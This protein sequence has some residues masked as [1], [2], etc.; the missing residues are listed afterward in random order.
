MK[1]NSTTNIKKDNILKDMSPSL[2]CIKDVSVLYDKNKKQYSVKL[3]KEIVE[4]L[5][6]EKKDILRFIVMVREGK[7]LEGRFGVVKK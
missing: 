4:L 3:P 2:D 6:I 5:G 7:P 1:N